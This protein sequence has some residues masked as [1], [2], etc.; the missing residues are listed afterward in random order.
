MGWR[1]SKPSARAL[2]STPWAIPAPRWCRFWN[3]CIGRMVPLAFV[4]SYLWSSSTVI[5]FLL[6]RLVDAT[7]MD[8][9]Y[10]PDEHDRHGL[11]PLKTGPD[12]VPQVADD[13]VL[14]GDDNSN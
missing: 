7:E 6:R 11:P 14:A 3:G 5:Y 10:S 4:F 9:V 1:D 12:G 8:E 13:P 2:T